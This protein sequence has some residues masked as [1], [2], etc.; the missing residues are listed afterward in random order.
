[1]ELGCCYTS[2]RVVTLLYAHRLAACKM[3][4][5]LVHSQPGLSPNEIARK[6]HMGRH[7]SRKDV[8]CRFSLTWLLPYLAAR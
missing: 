5:L 2:V 3:H 8:P 4:G 6:R 7:L 1:M